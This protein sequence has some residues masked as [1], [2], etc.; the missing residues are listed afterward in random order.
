MKEEETRKAEEIYGR[1]GL[2]QA[3]TKASPRLHVA[4]VRPWLRYRPYPILTAGSLMPGRALALILHRV[5]PVL[6]LASR[7]RME[8]Q[9]AYFVQQL[10][11]SQCLCNWAAWSGRVSRYILFPFFTIWFYR[12]IVKVIL[13]AIEIVKKGPLVIL[14]QYSLHFQ[15]LLRS[16]HLIHAR[17]GWNCNYSYN[18]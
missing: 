11:I 7:N 6:R 15:S 10:R 13:K 9:S 12:E 3:K 8:S 16:F 1:V 4:P 18:Q 2:K 14:F 5:I 17:N